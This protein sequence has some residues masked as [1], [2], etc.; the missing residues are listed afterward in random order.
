MT[1]DEDTNPASKEIMQEESIMEDTE[2]MQF[3]AMLTK[4]GDTIP[5]STKASLLSTYHYYSNSAYVSLVL[6]FPSFCRF[7]LSLLV[8]VIML[9]M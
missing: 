4:D 9:I 1:K 8:T 2:N 6:N 3:E 5:E 7:Y